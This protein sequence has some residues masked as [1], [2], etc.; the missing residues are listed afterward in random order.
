MILLLMR[1]HHVSFEESLMCESFVA[2]VTSDVLCCT[3]GKCVCLRDV[4]FERA[5]L[6]EYFAA[7][8]AHEADVMRSETVL[9]QLNLQREGIFAGAAFERSVTAVIDG[10]VMIQHVE[11]IE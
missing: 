2:N 8:F 7:L 10:D 11:I 3:V 5:F 4:H 9:I 6:G 1:A